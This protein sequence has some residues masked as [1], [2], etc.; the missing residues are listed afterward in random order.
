MTARQRILEVL[1]GVSPEGLS[2]SELIRRCSL[3]RGHARGLFDSMQLNGD[4]AITKIRREGSVTHICNLPG[5][6][7]E[8]A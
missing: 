1:E 3:E 2:K 8:A 6:V 4:I 7:D 5:D